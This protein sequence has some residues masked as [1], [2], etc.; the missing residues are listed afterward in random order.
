MGFKTATIRSLTLGDGIPKLCI[1]VTA[2]SFGELQEQMD[3]ILASPFD[4]IEWRADFFR[5]TK[6]A[7]W[8]IRTLQLLREKLGDN[9][10]LLFTFRTKEEGGNRAVSLEEYGA[11]TLEAA[12]SG[13]ADLVDI[14]LNRGEDLLR[15]LTQKAQ[16]Q[17]C[18]VVGSFHDF[19]KTRPK[20]E[21]I[22]ILT[23]MQD[24][25]VDLTKAAMMPETGQDVLELLEAALAMREQYAD[26][27][28]VL[29]SMGRLGAVSRLA[30]GLT[31]SALTFA[32]AGR[33][34][35]PG[36]MDAELV[37]RLLSA[38]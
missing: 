6:C 34:S 27:P 32:T 7:G 12:S 15:G 29:M 38:L 14:E 9:T 25:G 36:Q 18:R 2:E 20:E 19:E 8:L 21:T 5:E 31:G 24:C 1:P 17:G 26:R 33:A 13:F 3:R 30:G 16:A 35:A 37:H 23:S 28:Y 22:R 10:P 11:L 4:L